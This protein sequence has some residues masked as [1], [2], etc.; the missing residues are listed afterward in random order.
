MPCHNLPGSS[1]LL[2]GNPHHSSSS[3]TVWPAATALSTC[4]NSR[5]LSSLSNTSSSIRWSVDLR[6]QSGQQPTGFNVKPPVWLRRN[7]EDIQPDWTAF[8]ACN[9]QTVVEV[10][11]STLYC[12]TPVGLM[13]VNFSHFTTALLTCDSQW[14]RQEPASKHHSPLIQPAVTF[15]RPARYEKWHQLTRLHA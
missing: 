14:S 3:R 7:G 11:G 12:L 2:K 4:F 9:R 6:W 1:P 13:R 5:L 10:R 8:N 15:I